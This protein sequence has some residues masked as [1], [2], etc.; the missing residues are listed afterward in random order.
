MQSFI[1]YSVAEKW[2]EKRGAVN[3]E[4]SGYGMDENLSDASDRASQMKSN[5]GIDS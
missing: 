1:C 4:L 3:F 2:V 5:S